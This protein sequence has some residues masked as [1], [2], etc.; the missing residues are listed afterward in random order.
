MAD[1]ETPEELRINPD[2]QDT[3]P[4]EWE[5]D[6]RGLISS[7]K[8]LKVYGLQRNRLGMSYLLPQMG[9]KHSDGE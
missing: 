3:T 9:F 4:K 7:E 5:L 8:W 1:I 2:L 6:V